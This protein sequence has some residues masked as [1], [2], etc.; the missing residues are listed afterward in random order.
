[1][2]WRRFASVTLWLAA[3]ASLMSGARAAYLFVPLLLI[4]TYALENGYK[5]VL[6]VMVMLP[7]VALLAMAI[8][9]IN[10]G[11]MFEM[12]QDL[13][14]NYSSDIAVEGLVDAV[15]MAP[16]GTGTG[17]NTGP[18]RYALADPESLI[19]IENYYAKAVVE[20]G[21][22]GLLVVVILFAL[23]MKHGYTI[24]R[25][26]RDPG[27]KST[28][29]AFL[30]FIVTIVLNNFKGWQIDL[31]PVNVYFWM[32]AGFML[33]LGYLEGEIPGGGA[34]MPVSGSGSLSKSR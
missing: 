19:G 26:L 27:L 13:F 21:V 3:I 28:S 32:F 12:M 4:I 23:L 17:M 20:L 2:A 34:P 16:L 29:A 9:G 14:L 7:P 33:K 10:P 30:A 15:D 24:R 11:R 6:K 25:H 31:D 22:V 18:A 1:M 5:G 8:A